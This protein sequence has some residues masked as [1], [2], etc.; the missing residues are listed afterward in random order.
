MEKKKLTSVDEYIGSFP[1]EIQEILKKIIE[2][3]KKVAPESKQII[4]YQMPTLE[5][6]GKRFYFAANKKHIGVYAIYQPVSFEEEL[7]DYRSTKDTVQFLLD[8]PI[9]YDI[10]E[11]LIHYKLLD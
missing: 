8:Q 5:L 7:T 4:S 9:P 3:G 11:K 1:E 2:L 10:I 6:N